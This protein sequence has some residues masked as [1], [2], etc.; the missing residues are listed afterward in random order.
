MTRKVVRTSHV[1]TLLWWVIRDSRI[2]FAWECFQEVIIIRKKSIY[3]FTSVTIFRKEIEGS[4]S[5][6]IDFFRIYKDVV[7]DQLSIIKAIKVWFIAFAS[8]ATS[9]RAIIS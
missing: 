3:Q 1:A 5:A 7:Y 8:H 9:W 4:N 6:R 2:R